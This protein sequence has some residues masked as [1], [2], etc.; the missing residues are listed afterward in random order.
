[1]TDRT[2]QVMARN[3]TAGLVVDR[4]GIVTET[5]PILRYMTGWVEGKMLDYCRRKGWRVVEV[6]EKEKQ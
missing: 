4:L 2:Y 3:F 6:K 1:M 5:A